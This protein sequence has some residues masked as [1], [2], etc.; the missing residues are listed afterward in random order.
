M[1]E[2]ILGSWCSA[3]IG[4]VAEL[5]VADAMSDEPRSATALAQQLGTDPDCLHRLLAT[6]TDIGLFQGHNPGH[7]S[8]TAL[9]RTMRDDTA[10]S[11]RG[12]AR[13]VASP[14]ERG[15]TAYLAEAVRSGN[16]VFEHAH[17]KPA[18]AFLRDNPGVQAVFNAGMSDISA[19]ITAGV[20]SAYDFS[21][22]HTLVDVGG[23]QGRLLAAILAAHP[24][25]QGVLYD[26]PE[27]VEQAQPVL[28]RAGVADRCRVLGGDFLT[29]VP[30][31]GDAYLL[32]SVIHNWDDAQAAH[33]LS[34]CR[35]AASTKGRVLMAEAVLPPAGHH[36]LAIRLL[37]LSML[38]N[39]N[40]RQRTETEFA[41]LCHQA[42]LS[43]VRTH[44]ASDM[45]SLLEA[46]RRS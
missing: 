7:F 13:W 16:A 15:S 4:A 43:L 35:D 40:G 14:T 9:G 28:K 39:C 46:R 18:F 32:S 11:M 27:V 23:G 36:A 1:Y 38:A 21:A 3:V 24:H 45:C 37:D 41:D 12:F 8:L 34:L 33:I 25:L 6:G 26:Q 20:V 10:D 5:G 22:H 29:E 42:G 31:G 30:Q 44:Q 2:L 17:G 19:Q